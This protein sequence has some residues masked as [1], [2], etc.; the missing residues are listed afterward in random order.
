MYLYSLLLLLILSLIS[1][2]EVKGQDTASEEDQSSP[3]CIVLTNSKACPD[4]EGSSLLLANGFYNSQQEFDDFIFSQYDNNNDYISKFQDS[5]GCNNYNGRGQRYHISYYCSLMI[6]AS[7]SSCSTG[8]PEK[9]ICKDTCTKAKNA[10]N[11]IFENENMCEQ[12]GLSSTQSQSRSNSLN[13]YDNFCNSLSLTSN[14]GECLDGTLSIE[15]NT[16]GFFFKDDFDNFCKTDVGKNDKCCKSKD[17]NSKVIIIASVIGS[18]ALLSIIIITIVCIK[19]RK[20]R[21]D[22]RNISLDETTIYDQSNIGN[23]FRNNSKVRFDGNVKND[24]SNYKIDRTVIYSP[25][26][27][28]NDLFNIPISSNPSI[29]SNYSNKFNSSLN[30]LQ[31]AS[32]LSPNQFKNSISYPISPNYNKS[33][34]SNISSPPLSTVTPVLTVLSPSMNIN[35]N[36]VTIHHEEEEENNFNILEKEMKVWAKYNPLMNDE[37]KLN[38]DD[39]VFVEIVYDDGWARG[40]NLNTGQVGAF[41]MAAVILPDDDND[42]ALSMDSKNRISSYIN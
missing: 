3:Q 19:K 39:I 23:P 36:I 35:D 41:P 4:W 26:S 2:K 15:S 42:Q 22:N 5:Y 9:T 25:N 10:L 33:A 13:T 16:C 38:S 21:V 11:D 32:P 12:Q 24:N 37:I 40:K 34:Y 20:N 8:P 29:K 31:A 28:D 7:Q 1:I 17:E 6:Y 14:S 18:I 27:D 30:H